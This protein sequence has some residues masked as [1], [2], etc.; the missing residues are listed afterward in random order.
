M[1]AHDIDNHSKYALDVETDEV[2][3]LNVETNDSY[4]DPVGGFD[5]GRPVE[6]GLL[7]APDGHNLSSEEPFKTEM[8][9][10]IRMRVEEYDE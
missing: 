3:I 2:V 7:Y 10:R 6:G 4:H 1:L 8:W 9:G 5:D